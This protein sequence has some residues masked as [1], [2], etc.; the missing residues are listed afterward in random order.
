MLKKHKTLENKN[1]EQSLHL[2]TKI[3][4][5][6]QDFENLMQKFKGLENKHYE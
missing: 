4:Q 3:D 2:E 6:H 5:K 1:Y